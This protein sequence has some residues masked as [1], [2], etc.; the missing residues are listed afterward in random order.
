LLIGTAAPVAAEEV[1]WRYDY[2]AARKEAKDRNKPIVLDFGTANCH[3]CKQLDASTFRDP[4]VIKALTEHVIPVKIDAGKEPELAQALGINSYPT[5]IFAAPNGKILGQQDGYIEA[6]A[7]SRQLDRLFGSGDRSNSK[8]SETNVQAG[9]RARR[10]QEAKAKDEKEP[11]RLAQV[12]EKLIDSLGNAYLELAES[13]LR[14]GQAEQALSYLEK[15]VRTCPGTQAAQLAQERIFQVRD[16]LAKQPDA[17]G[18][19]RTQM[20]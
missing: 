1:P 14:K 12:C 2:N 5:L 13:L 8:P 9:D 20:P 4:A 19:V 7:F 6:A 15:A 18:V 3:W 17:K 10:A 11:E 16:Q